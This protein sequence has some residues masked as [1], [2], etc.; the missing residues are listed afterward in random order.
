MGQ[1]LL[2]W[3]DVPSADQLRLIESLGK[4]GWYNPTDEELNLLWDLWVTEQ[5]VKQ[6]SLYD[7][8]MEKYGQEAKKEGWSLFQYN[9]CGLT[10]IEL[11]RV[12]GSE[13]V[14]DLS[15][16]IHVV[17]KADQIPDSAA[18][19]AMGI[20]EES[21]RDVVKKSVSKIRGMES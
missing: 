17:E 12:Q 9:D 14:D 10:L 18:A 7:C 5:N 4:G 20:L 2:G 3:G 15:V 11:L 21:Y 13:F 19:A 8:W 6:I 16:W 1:R